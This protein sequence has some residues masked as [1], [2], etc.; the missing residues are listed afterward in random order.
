MS[1]LSTEQVKFEATGASDLEATLERMQAEMLKVRVQS[2]RLNQSL[3]D[4]SFAKLAQESRKA[5]DSLKQVYAQQARVHEQAK[6]QVMDAKYGSTFGGVAY[7][8]QRYGAQVQNAFGQAMGGFGH[9]AA[10]VGVPLGVGALVSQ[11][12]GGTAPAA[13]LENAL[14]RLARKL[15]ADATPAVDWFTRQINKM[16]RASDRIAA[17]QG[18]LG[19]RITA[20]LPW[21]AGLG[22]PLAMSST[23]R[24]GAMSGLGMIGSLGGLM[25]GMNFGG[26][27]LP[28]P[29]PQPVGANANSLAGGAAG[30]AAAG[31]FAGA[32]NF[33]KGAGAI[34]ALY[35]TI[36][37]GRDL[38]R[39]DYESDLDTE[40]NKQANEAKRRAM[41]QRTWM[42]RNEKAVGRGGGLAGGAA[43][44]AGIGVWFGGIGAVPGALIGAGIGS[45]LGDAVTENKEPT[46][47]D[48]QKVKANRLV[49]TAETGQRADMR[50]VYEDIQSAFGRLSTDDGPRQK[51]A[52]GVANAEGWKGGKYG[53]DWMAHVAENT[54]AVKEN[55]DEIKRI[56]DKFWR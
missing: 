31:R 29:T 46:W 35:E 28:T 25:N 56:A 36:Q 26:P 38:A 47:K 50:A 24:N 54:A 22:I 20:N 10:A 41:D 19:D 16:N 52:D 14:D 12:F 7:N 33:I 13:K 18:S 55:T 15:A 51:P 1:V 11:G 42:E 40:A 6:R 53:D 39:N 44:G 3:N 21:I 37:L 17:G 8:A 23:A 30:G 34:A 32:G 27:Q 5:A 4:G 49:K 43:I 9:A 48:D 2:G 45:L